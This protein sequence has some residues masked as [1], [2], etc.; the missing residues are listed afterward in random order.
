[1]SIAIA[2]SG[3]GRTA[4]ERRRGDFCLPRLGIAAFC[5]KAALGSKSALGVFCRPPPL[6][7]DSC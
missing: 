6:L 5:P 3:S 2:M 1:M 4:K 7:A